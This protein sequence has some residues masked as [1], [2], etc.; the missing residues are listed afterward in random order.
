MPALKKIGIQT[1]KCKMKNTKI[2]QILDSVNALPSQS[3]WE[4]LESNIQ[5]KYRELEAFFIDG[6][7]NTSKY[8]DE[9]AQKDEELC[10]LFN[11][12]H[13]IEEEAEQPI[14]NTNQ[15]IEIN[16]ELENKDVEPKKEETENT[17]A[18]KNQVEE[19]QENKIAQNTELENQETEEMKEKKEIEKVEFQ[20]QTTEKEIDENSSVE[21][22]PDLTEKNEE[23]E[24]LTDT[25]G[26]AVVEENEEEFSEF[27]DYARERKI[28]KASDF[29]KFKIPQSVW[30]SN[31]PEI[32]MGDLKFVKE[33][34]A[35]LM[36]NCWTVKKIEQE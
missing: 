13:E 35:Q 3:E 1:K 20:E 4:I 18:E 32:V 17:E 11:E 7:N 9:I 28:I 36:L 12:H 8:T 25:D 14:V 19:N 15:N 30:H 21:E 27:I 23:I 26:D 6:S 31:K 16:Q 10:K 34:P 22:A 2:Y 24:E 33:N 5:E 29:T